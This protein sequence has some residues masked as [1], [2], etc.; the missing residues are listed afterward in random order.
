ML[1]RLTLLLAM[2]QAACDKD[3][4]SCWECSVVTITNESFACTDPDKIEELAASNLQ[5]ICDKADKDAYMAKH[6][7]ESETLPKDCPDGIR[8]YV[9]SMS[10]VCVPVE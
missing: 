6:A 2:F 3:A 1:V 8:P 9:V 7:L 10:P 4:S 5:I